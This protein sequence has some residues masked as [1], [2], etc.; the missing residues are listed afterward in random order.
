MRPALGRAKHDKKNFSPNPYRRRLEQTASKCSCSKLPLVSF[1][2]RLDN[3]AAL[4]LRRNI[5]K[6]SQVITEMTAH[7]AHKG[8]TEIK[9][10]SEDAHVDICSVEA[11]S[12]R[13][14][15]YIHHL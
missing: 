4:Q 8:E 11:L 6:L 12:L 1:K 2:W 10:Y 5:Y 3:I 9:V 14:L 13:C 7:N 15:S